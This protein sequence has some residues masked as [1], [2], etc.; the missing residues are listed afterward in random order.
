RI[1]VVAFVGA[2]KSIDDLPVMNWRYIRP[3]SNGKSADKLYAAPVV[4][5]SLSGDGIENGDWL[6]V[7]TNF[8]QHKIRPGRLMVALTPYGLLAK[9]IYLG[10][11]GQIRLV[12]SN[13]A[14]DDIV[15]DA[16]EVHLQGVVIRRERDL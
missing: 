2:A 4:G 14:F 3:I 12:S 9:H 7:R 8:E 6:I 15:L 13:P 11:N 16:D 5:D 10:L 1:P